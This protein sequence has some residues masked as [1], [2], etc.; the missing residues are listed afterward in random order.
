MKYRLFLSIASA[1][2]WGAKRIERPLA[3]RSWL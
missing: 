2:C 3:D 1:G